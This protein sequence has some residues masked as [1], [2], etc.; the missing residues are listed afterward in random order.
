MESLYR[1][2]GDAI[3]YWPSRFLAAVRR[4]GGLPYAKKLL[5]PG[6]TSAGFDRVAE[7][8]RADLSVEYLALD[9]R[10][11][12]LFTKDERDEAKSRLPPLSGP[13]FPR[14]SPPDQP[15]TVGELSEKDVYKEGDVQRVTVNRYERDAKARNACIDHHGLRCAVCDLSLEERYGDPG[16][17]FIHV[18]HKRPLHRL[19]ASNPV[20]PKTDLVPVCP[21]CHA[22]LH[23]RD[24]PYDVEQLRGML[25]PIT[26]QPAGDQ[27]AV[28]SI[29]TPRD[30]ASSPTPPKSRGSGGR[31]SKASTEARCS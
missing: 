23:R 24:P 29:S 12:H 21:N 7:A 18:H 15:A 3:D 1:R 11:R 25:R 28:R 20:N 14:L 2:T 16:K 5:A 22:I 30:N 17:G 26:Q 8:G 13:A 9:Q 27:G 31:R 6:T 10:F 4:H 19:R